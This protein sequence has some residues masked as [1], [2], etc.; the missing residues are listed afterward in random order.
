ME[1]NNPEPSTLVVV[2]RRL[3][4]VQVRVFCRRNHGAEANYAYQ[5][6]KR[7]KAST[8]VGIDQLLSKSSTALIRSQTLLSRSRLCWDMS[9][10][11]SASLKEIMPNILHVKP[12]FYQTDSSIMNGITGLKSFQ[13]LLSILMSLKRRIVDLRPFSLQPFLHGRNTS[14]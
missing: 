9:C 13:F 11:R 6:L 14:V 10:A 12:I 7:S 4:L 2:A 8:I 1:G 3:C 5:E